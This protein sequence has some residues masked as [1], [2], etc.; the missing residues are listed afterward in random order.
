MSVEAVVPERVET[1]PAD[2]ALEEEVRQSLSL[3]ALTGISSAVVLGLAMLAV[4]V[5]G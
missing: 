2:R 3:L 1:A 4:R 5:L